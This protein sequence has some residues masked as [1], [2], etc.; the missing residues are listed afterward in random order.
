[1]IYNH[2]IDMIIC[3]EICVIFWF[4]NNMWVMIWWYW[5]ILIEAM[6]EFTYWMNEMMIN[7]KY[8]VFYIWIEFE[9]IYVNDEYIYILCKYNV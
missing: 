2:I 6:N 7:D 1:M 8:I 5:F 4:I 9:M 3:Y